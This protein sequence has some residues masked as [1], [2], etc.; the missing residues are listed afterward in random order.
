MNSVSIFWFRRDLR[1][2]DNV[3]FLEA[4]KSDYPVLPIFIFDKEI[5]D[6]LDKERKYIKKF[7]PEYDTSEYPEKMVDHKEARER[8]LKIYKQ[9]LS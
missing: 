4:L 6:K 3:G 7:I 9:A 1:L 2:D 8:C 5:L